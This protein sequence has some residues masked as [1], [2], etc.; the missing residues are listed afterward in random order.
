MVY[1]VHLRSSADGNGDG[2][3][4][5]PGLRRRLPHLADLGVDALW[6]TP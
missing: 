5:V 2:L 3:G 6:V 1:E 4:D